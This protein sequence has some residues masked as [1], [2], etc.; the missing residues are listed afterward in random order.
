MSKQYDPHKSNIKTKG[1]KGKKQYE[2]LK[3]MWA[4][5]IRKRRIELNTSQYELSRACGL[6][7]NVVYN[8]E[9]GDTTTLQTYFFIA[10]RLE[11]KLTLEHLEFD[12]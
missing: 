2:A 3:R 7:K 6:S 8:V 12:S 10:D 5:R 9:K 4:E 1:L 11:L